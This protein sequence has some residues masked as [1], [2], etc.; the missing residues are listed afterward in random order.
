MK[1]VKQCMSCKRVYEA[2]PDSIS[3]IIVPDEVDPVLGVGYLSICSAD[4]F[5]KACDMLK[6]TAQEA[7]K[8]LE[9]EVEKEKKK[10]STPG[11]G[12]S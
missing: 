10:A 4:C 6:K 8:E 1:A 9:E 2:S 12:L 5:I 3:I 7:V 11:N